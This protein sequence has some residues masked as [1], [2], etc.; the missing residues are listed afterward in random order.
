MLHS[1]HDKEPHQFLSQTKE[2]E[3]EEPA[4]KMHE[5]PRNYQRHQV[6]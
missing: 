1:E 3:E 6:E 4:A 5:R 2:T